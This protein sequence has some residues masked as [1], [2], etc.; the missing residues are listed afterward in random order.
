M[1][2]HK[3]Q[4]LIGY[5][6]IHDFGGKCRISGIDGEQRSGTYSTSCSAT[7][8]LYKQACAGHPN[9]GESFAKDRIETYT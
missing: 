8:G 3:E 7:S 5:G 6:G 4:G 9:S 1:C 2:Y